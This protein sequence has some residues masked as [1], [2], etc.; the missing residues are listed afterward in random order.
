MSEEQTKEQVGE[1][2][3]FLTLDEETNDYVGKQ[4]KKSD[5]V[6]YPR[7][8]FALIALGGMQ[9][10]YNEQLEAFIVTCKPQTLDN[11]AH[12]YK[13]GKWRNPHLSPDHRLEFDGVSGD[14]YR[15]VEEYLNLPDPLEEPES[16]E[17]EFD[18]QDDQEYDDDFS[19]G[20]PDDDDGQPNDEDDGL[21]YDDREP[22]GYP[23]WE[24]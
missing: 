23:G 5:L 20:G 15:S 22:G 9:G 1:K 13:T 4:I 19:M 10:G 14:F 2:I 7:S 8:L 21:M 12:F 3:C 6:K 16:D 11:I 18:D 24:Y 17:Q